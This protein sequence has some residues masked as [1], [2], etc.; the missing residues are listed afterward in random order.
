MSRIILCLFALTIASLLDSNFIIALNLLENSHTINYKEVISLLQFSAESGNPEAYT[1]LGE[2]YLLGFPEENGQIYYNY[3]EAYQYFIKGA[4]LESSNS[5]FF[6][7]IIYQENLLTDEFQNIT[8]IIDSNEIR[9]NMIKGLRMNKDLFA[10][11]H[12]SAVTQCVNSKNISIPEFLERSIYESIGPALKFPFLNSIECNI[13]RDL[14]YLAMLEA[15]KAVDHI[16]RKGKIEHDLKRIDLELNN[17][18]GE[19]GEKILSLFAKQFEEHSITMGFTSIGETYMFGDNALGINKNPEEGLKYFE[20]ALEMGDTNAAAVLG[21]LYTQG[22]G[23]EANY[24]RAYEYLEKAIAGGSV[25]AMISMGLLYRNGNGVT[26]NYTKAFE[27]TKMASDSGN[28]ESLSNL[29]V[30]YLNGEG[31]ERNLEK[32]VEYMKK[33][34]GTGFYGA[35]FNLG[36]LHID[37]EGVE[38]SQEKAFQFFTEVIYQ[39]KRDGY[40]NKAYKYFRKGNM[41]SAYLSYVIASA[42][43]YQSARLSLAYMY[44]KALTGNKCLLGKEY[45]IGTYLF[46]SIIHD[47]DQWANEQLAKILYNGGNFF[48]SDYEKAHKFYLNAPPSGEVL[49]ALGY[50]YEEGLGCE[51]NYDKALEYYESIISQ[52]ETSGIDPGAS[53][54]AMIAKYKL[55][56]KMILNYYMNSSF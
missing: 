36:L 10:L 7:H 56:S 11:S 25:Q 3:K 34:A 1:K 9:L 5:R 21:T 53:Y 8:E 14:V 28:I 37:G 32:A 51:K 54:P 17:A 52:A 30:F 19:E 20:K 22:I 45:C 49:F 43:G 2:L 16:Q 18:F 48:A 38:K 42:L 15:R 33:A 27:Y 35:K 50:M 4:N 12:I 47:N 6:L 55:K 23:V 13:S 40:V 46:K 31:V 24:S 29:A 26:R 39:G 44:D 41:R